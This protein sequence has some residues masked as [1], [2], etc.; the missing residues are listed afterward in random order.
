MR[1]DSTP[2]SLNTPYGRPLTAIMCCRVEE[3]VPGGG[4]EP[5]G[6]GVG[7]L[8]AGVPVAVR[9]A[10][11]ARGGDDDGAG[12]VARGPH[13]GARQARLLPLGRRR[14]GALGRAR[15]HRLH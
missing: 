3:A 6:L 7:G 10:R 9:A 12:G 13:H 8:R 1:F 11:A 2:S 15:A 4:A 14:H 5:V